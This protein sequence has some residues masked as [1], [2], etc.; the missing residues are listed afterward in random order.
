MKQKCNFQMGIAI[1]GVSYVF[2]QL[3][4]GTIRP[5]LTFFDFIKFL[6]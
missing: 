6:D 3:S 4:E 1:Q 2:E 5:M